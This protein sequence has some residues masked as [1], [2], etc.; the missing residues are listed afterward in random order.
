MRKLNGDSSYTQWWKLGMSHPLINMKI[1]NLTV[2]Y[3]FTLTTTHSL[4]KFMVLP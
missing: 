3:S 2:T 1:K 4:V